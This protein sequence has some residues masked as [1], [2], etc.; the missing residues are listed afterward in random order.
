MPQ[1]SVIFDIVQLLDGQ[2]GLTAA[3]NFF[4]GEWGMAATGEEIDSQVCVY[5]TGG[6]DSPLRL[7]YEQP[8]FQIIVRGKR[9]ENN[10]T[11]YNLLRQIHEYLIGLEEPVDING[12]CYLGFEPQGAIV[13]LGR[14]ENDRFMY[15]INYYSYR[16]ATA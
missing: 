4:A 7:L 9:G 2:F 10:Q 14:D 1:N 11:P 13:Q 16:N 5:E 15:S 3:Q 12:A 8:T 6:F